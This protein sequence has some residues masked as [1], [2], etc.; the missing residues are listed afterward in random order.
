MG[1]SVLGELAQPSVWLV[2]KV[3][4]LAVIALYNVFAVVVVKQVNHM[5]NTLEVGFEGV[6]RLVAWVHLLM[7]LATLMAAFVIL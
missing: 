7:A 1:E 4:A 2:A 3:L 6:I 5:T